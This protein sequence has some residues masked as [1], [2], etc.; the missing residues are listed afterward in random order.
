MAVY[1]TLYYAADSNLYLYMERKPHTLIAATQYRKAQDSV[2][3]REEIDMNLG[4]AW[5]RDSAL[6]WD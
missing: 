3:F 1:I 5:S 2:Y 6:G 4:F